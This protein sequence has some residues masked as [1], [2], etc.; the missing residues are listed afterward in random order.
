MEHQFLR[1]Q[2]SKAFDGSS[3]DSCDPANQEILL[4]VAVPEGP[5]DH[6]GPASGGLRSVEIRT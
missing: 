4:Q 5:L 1:S 3:S 6:A 2:A